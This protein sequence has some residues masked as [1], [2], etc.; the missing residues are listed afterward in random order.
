MN[1]MVRLVLCGIVVSSIA[2]VVTADAQ[3]GSLSKEDLITL[4]VNRRVS[5]CRMGDQWCRK[6]FWSA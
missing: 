3:V 1:R 6:T 4:T 5:D 2:R